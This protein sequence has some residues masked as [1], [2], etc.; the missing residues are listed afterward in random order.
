M[1][2]FNSILHPFQVSSSM[3]PLSFIN[4]YT[5]WQILLDSP[6]PLCYRETMCE[7]INVKNWKKVQ[8]FRVS[9]GIWVFTRGV[10]PVWPAAER[11]RVKQFRKIDSRV[12]VMSIF[13]GTGAGWWILKRG[14]PPTRN[15]FLIFF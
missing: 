4:F 10:R 14:Y 7:S 9:L 5:H 13:C 11:V 12:R 6:L 2:W 3:T 15:C 1:R 8:N